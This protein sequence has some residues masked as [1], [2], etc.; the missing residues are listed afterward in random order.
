MTIGQKRKLK[1]RVIRILTVNIPLIV[2]FLVIIFPIY[3]TVVT[4]LKDE[5]TILE[6]PIS[7]G[8]PPLPLTITN[9]F[10]R[11]WVLTGISLTA[12]L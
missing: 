3:W 9:I 1:K 6:L 7:I 4:S 8:L 10:G 12:C 5:S 2:L 11:I